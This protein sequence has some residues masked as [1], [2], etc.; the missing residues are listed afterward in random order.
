MFLRG[1]LNCGNEIMKHYIGFLELFLLFFL[2]SSYIFSKA[3]IREFCAT[4]TVLC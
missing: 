3:R 2:I 4:L 1:V